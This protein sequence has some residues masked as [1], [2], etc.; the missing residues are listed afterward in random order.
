MTTVN[1]LSI[2]TFD[3]FLDDI[4]KLKDKYTESQYKQFNLLP[5]M[6]NYLRWPQMLAI[7]NLDEATKTEVS[8]RLLNFVENYNRTSADTNKVL[9]EDE[10][11]Q[12]KRLVKFMNESDIGDLNQNRKDFK[13]FID[14]YDKRRGVNF[15]MT[16]P[17]LQQFYEVCA[18]V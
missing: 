3:Q 8:S 7:T 1:I 17:N 18:N 12:I 2:G 13:I 9:W 5:C 10:I 14:E 6:T 15:H 4:L 11:N 16:F